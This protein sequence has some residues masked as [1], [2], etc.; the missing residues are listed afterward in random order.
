M[1]VP[2]ILTRT[3]GVR[4]DRRSAIK[5]PGLPIRAVSDFIAEASKT[6]DKSIEIAIQAQQSIANLRSKD[7]GTSTSNLDLRDAEYAFYGYKSGAQFAKGTDLK[8]AFFAGSPAM[9]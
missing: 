2:R 7:A 9:R 4:T 8:D 5:S 1:R 6:A 3:N